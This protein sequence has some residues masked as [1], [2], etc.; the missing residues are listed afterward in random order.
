MTN[1]KLLAKPLGLLLV[2]GMMLVGCDTE[3]ENLAISTIKWE[4]AEDGFTRWYTN[5]PQYYDYY[6]WL[7]NENPNESNTYEIECKKISGDKNRA[8]GM[9][10]GASN[11]VGN[12]FYCVSITV[13]GYHCVWMQ[14]GNVN[15]IIKNWSLSGKLY[16]GYNKTNR[17]KVTKS[18]TKYTV[19]L[20]NNQV[21][22]FDD[23]TINGDRIG[24][25]VAI[26][27]ETDESF[28]NSPVDVR[29][30]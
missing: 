10:F 24:Y 14:N 12:R 23:G 30:K 5:D 9:I 28:P 13:E 11:L 2:F 6:F 7:L 15:E 1:R 8:Y 16:N 3:D 22:Q 19:Y 26:D 17:I 4:L 18:G 20:N 25:F 27:L 29:F 21:C